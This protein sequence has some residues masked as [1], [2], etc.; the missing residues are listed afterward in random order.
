MVLSEFAL[1]TTVLHFLPDLQLAQHGIANSCNSE[2]LHM[3]MRRDEKVSMFFWVLLWVPLA[4]IRPEVEIGKASAQTPS[5]KQLRQRQ[6]SKEFNQKVSWL[7][8]STMS[9]MNRNT[10]GNPENGGFC[11][12]CPL[13][14]K[15]EHCTRFMLGHLLRASELAWLLSCAHTKWSITRMRAPTAN[16]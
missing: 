1:Q 10:S 7:L 16:C 12:L 14:L 4:A 3:E 9:V 11:M 15:T 5:C 6:P 13:T 2:V 8:R